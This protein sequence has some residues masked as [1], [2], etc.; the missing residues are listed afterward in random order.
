MFHL[1][2]LFQNWR[3][4]CT[5]GEP[6]TKL[7]KSMYHWKSVFQKWKNLCT[8]GET[9]FKKARQFH[10]YPGTSRKPIKSHLKMQK[11]YIKLVEYT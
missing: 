6:I 11:G 1:R 3:N 7:E 5:T 10:S 8:T 4:L 2:S 9:N